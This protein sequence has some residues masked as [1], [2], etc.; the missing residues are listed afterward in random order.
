MHRNSLLSETFLDFLNMLP[1]QPTISSYGSSWCFIWCGPANSARSQ[2]PPLHKLAVQNNASTSWPP[3]KVNNSS[4]VISPSES[5]V[6]PENGHCIDECVSLLQDYEIIEDLFPYQ[7]APFSPSGNFSAALPSKILQCSP[8]WKRCCL[9]SATRK[10]CTFFYPSV[11]SRSLLEVQLTPQA[12]KDISSIS[13]LELL[14]LTSFHPDC[15]LPQTLS[16]RRG[17]GR[18]PC[19]PPPTL[20]HKLRKDLEDILKIDISFI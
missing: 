16:P 15:G 6:K 13:F 9:W 2:W 17:S 14:E 10:L 3:F 8:S 18:E 1:T 19:S 20:L 12:P 4:V 5:S 7:T 11:V